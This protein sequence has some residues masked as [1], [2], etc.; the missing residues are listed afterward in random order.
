MNKAVFLD[1]DGVINKSIII[2]G[3]PF[4]PADLASLE[5][6][7]GVKE[8]IFEL[9]QAGYLVFVVTNQPDVAR[10]KTKK[11]SI[12]EIHNF[13]KSH[14]Q[15]DA[16]ECCFHDNTDNCNC[17]KPQPGMILRLMDEWQVDVKR[18]YL[19]GDRWRDIQAALNA[20][21]TS[22]LIDYKY[23]EKYEAPDFSCSCFNEA[24]DYILNK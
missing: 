6:M 24:V 7:E 22:I 17:R 16:I 15:I 10:G 1:R 9:R 5:L 3:R 20:G 2:N 11:E 13:L 8:K 4:P 23:D 14:L 18:S 19:I 12:D 21:V